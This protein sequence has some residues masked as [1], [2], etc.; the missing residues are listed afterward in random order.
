MP[1]IILKHDFIIYKK[2]D[3]YEIG[4]VK[5]VDYENNKA[6]VFYHTGGT[7]SCTPF[8]A[9][10]FAYPVIEPIIFWFK[11][12]DALIR[13]YH[14]LPSLILRRYALTGSAI[15]DGLKSIDTD[16]LIDVI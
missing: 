15:F 10:V 12:N 4:L 9:I 3:K 13:N 6:F 1:G 2:G 11:E 16:D 14:A 7:A 8:D 5:S